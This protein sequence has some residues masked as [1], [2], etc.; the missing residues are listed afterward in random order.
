MDNESYV[1]NVT[2]NTT[3]VK[4]N[5]YDFW[6]KL[7]PLIT[8]YTFCA[9][10]FLLNLIELV[11]FYRK[12]CELSTNNIVLISLSCA[13]LLYVLI[14]PI[15]ITLYIKT[16]KVA[17]GYFYDSLIIFAI[18]NSVLHLLLMAVDR[19]IAITKPFWHHIVVSKKKVAMLCLG[20]WLLTAIL[21]LAIGFHKKSLFDE[22]GISMHEIYA[23]DIYVIL[24]LILIVSILIPT[25]YIYICIKIVRRSRNLTNGQS[26]EQHHW[27][28]AKTSGLICIS[29]ILLNAPFAIQY[30]IKVWNIDKWLYIVQ[31]ANCSVN[32]LIYFWINHSHRTRLIRYDK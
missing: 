20:I 13:D 11:M 28:T 4:S 5:S 16:I 19:L 30:L 17:H 21:I 14:S 32:S 12:K 27:K 8:M 15:T 18:F 31:L 7:G 9:I 3:S 25:I 26:R 2:T 23:V 10:G 6:H 24:S 22:T 1:Y 29:F